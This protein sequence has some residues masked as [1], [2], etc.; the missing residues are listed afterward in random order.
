MTISE[1]NG[2]SPTMNTNCFSLIG[3]SS[4]SLSARAV[5]PR[6]P[7]R[8]SASSPKNPSGSTVSITRSS[9]RMST[10]PAFTTYMKSG[11]SPAAKMVSPA[12]KVFDALSF[13]KMLGSFTTAIL[14]RSRRRRRRL[15]HRD[16]EHHDGAGGVGLGPGRGHD[17]LDGRDV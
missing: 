7:A 13:S 2:V 9:F 15:L 12:R 3:T 11:G 8:T 5:G 17:V 16:A 6:T 10:R 4:Q 14:P 1:K